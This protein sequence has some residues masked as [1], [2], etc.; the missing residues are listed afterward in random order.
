MKL[1]TLISYGSPTLLD[2]LEEPNANN[3]FTMRHLKTRAFQFS[4]NDSYVV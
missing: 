1:H 2:L 4:S 3:C